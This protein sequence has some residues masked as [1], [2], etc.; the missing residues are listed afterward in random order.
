[1]K[2]AKE[3]M[4]HS[5]EHCDQ[6]ETLLSVVGQMSKSNIGSLPVIDEDKKVI[7]I[8]TNHDVCMAL[9]KTNK[10]P[11]EIKVHEVMS[12]NVHTCSQEDDAP[13]VLKI[14]RTNRVSRLPVIDE[15]NKLRGILS[16]NRMIRRVYDGSDKDEILFKGKENV[17]NT[18][19]SITQENLGYAEEHYWE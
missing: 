6:H 8:V 12:T 15:D 7:G 3:I 4:V 11:H 1:M 2:T 10:P 17:L 9:G 19:R 18:L 5:P 13:T 14:M 16:L